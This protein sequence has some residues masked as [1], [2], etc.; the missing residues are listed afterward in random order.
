MPARLPYIDTVVESIGV[1]VSAGFALTAI[2]RERADPAVRFLEAHRS[3]VRLLQLLAQSPG[4]S[5]FELHLVSHPSL[6]SA[7]PGSIELGLVIRTRAACRETS[8]EC[9][10]S[11]WFAIDPLLRTFWRV[12]RRWPS[13]DRSTAQSP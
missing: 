13:E 4:P 12:R 8:I 3:T 1:R 6:D 2:D 10:L 7:Q 9:C 5:I 11:Q